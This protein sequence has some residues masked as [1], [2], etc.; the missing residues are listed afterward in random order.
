MYDKNIKPVFHVYGKYDMDGN[1]VATDGEAEILK[2]LIVRW[3][4]RVSDKVD[5]DTDFVVMGKEPTVPLYTPEELQN[6]II[7]SKKDEAEAALKAFN[8]VRDSAVSIHVPVLNQ[9]RFLYYTGYF[10]SAKK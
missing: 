6:P 1:G 5:V 9:N 2:N 7:K 3:G 10:D 8:D 4:G